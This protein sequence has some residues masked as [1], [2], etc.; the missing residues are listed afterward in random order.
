MTSPVSQ[1]KTSQGAWVT[2][3]YMPAHM[4]LPTLPES[5]DPRIRFQDIQKA[6]FATIQFSGSWKQSNLIKH[7]N[8]LVSYLQS[9]DYDYHPEPIYAFYNAP[10][11]PWFLR[12]NEIMFQLHQ[13]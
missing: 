6:L 7:T 9:N 4:T 11:V 10:Y 1:Q 3:F 2:T 13:H 8:L 12:R 5:K